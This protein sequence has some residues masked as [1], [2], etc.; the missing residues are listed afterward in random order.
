MANS[1][2]PTGSQR[3]VASTAEART[4]LGCTPKTARRWI[5]NGMLDGYRDHSGLYYFHLPPRFLKGPHVESLAKD[6]GQG[7]RSASSVE[8]TTTPTTDALRI[9]LAAAKEAITELQDSVTSEKAKRREAEEAQRTLLASNALTIEAA[10]KL[11]A[12]SELLQAGGADLLKALELQR[13][14][15][16]QFLISADLTQL[17]AIS[18]PRGDR[19]L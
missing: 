13:G 5:T 17:E 15:L 1:N 18:A 6:S 16:A 12:G 10:Q 2:E 4:L 8:D 7:G 11:S 14:L 9:E 19:R 3:P